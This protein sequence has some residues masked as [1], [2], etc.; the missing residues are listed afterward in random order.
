M[1]CSVSI[2]YL[3]GVS[4]D[5]KEV[6]RL[7]AAMNLANAFNN[8][9][10]DSDSLLCRSVAQH[11]AIDSAIESLQAQVHHQTPQADKLHHQTPQVD[12][13]VHGARPV[14]I[15]RVSERAQESIAAGLVRTRLSQTVSKETQASIRA[16]LA[17]SQVGGMDSLL[18]VLEP[19]IDALLNHK[20]SEL[21]A[22]KSQLEGG[23]NR[24]LQ[25]T[26]IAT[27]LAASNHVLLLCNCFTLLLLPCYGSALDLAVL[28]LC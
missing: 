11:N 21:A 18:E 16:G 26:T 14:D 27:V 2:L 3:T 15:S 23:S 5:S 20:K 1:P 25:C 4:S 6:K 24:S 19:D 12:T 28:L 22:E 17:R 7:A 8:R 10:W 9:K 13:Q